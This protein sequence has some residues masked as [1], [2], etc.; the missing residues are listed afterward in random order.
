MIWELTTYELDGRWGV[1]GNSPIRG[2][3]FT[4]PPVH[5]SDEDAQAAGTAWVSRWEASL[6]A[7][8]TP[9]TTF[10]IGE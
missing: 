4:I 6:S 8:E 5:A 1:R 7:S 10:A 3:D 9:G 2:V